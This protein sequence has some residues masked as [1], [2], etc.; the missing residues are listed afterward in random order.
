[1][2]RNPAR[3]ILH[4]AASPAFLCLLGIRLFLNLKEAGRVEAKEGAEN[5]TLS[6][7]DFATL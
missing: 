2:Q 1:M 7:I 5:A 3:V 4:A 6:S